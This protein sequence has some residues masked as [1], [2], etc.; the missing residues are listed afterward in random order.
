[1]GDIKGK[2]KTCA[3][4][5]AALYL[6][7]FSTWVGSAF[8]LLNCLFSGVLVWPRYKH[9]PDVL[10]QSWKEAEKHGM[11]RRRSRSSFQKKT[12]QLVL[13]LTE[14]EQATVD[15]RAY[16]GFIHG[17]RGTTCWPAVCPLFILPLHFCWYP[18][19]YK[20]TLELTSKQLVKKTQ[21]AEWCREPLHS[22][23]SSWKHQILTHWFNRWT[24]LPIKRF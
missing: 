8:D 7:P 17:A 20:W 2:N 10:D 22:Q 3:Q 24:F 16:L 12:Q 18:G 14:L 6:R 15:L 13:S 4:D 19:F 23:W 5:S 1:M 11:K 9:R 21:H